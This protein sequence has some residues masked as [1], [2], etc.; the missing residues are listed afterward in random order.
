MKIAGSTLAASCVALASF[1]FNGMNCLVLCAYRTSLFFWM[2]VVCIT[3]EIHLTTSAH[4]Q[5]SGGDRYFPTV[6]RAVLVD[7]FLYLVEFI[8]M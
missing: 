3:R 7:N 6:C 8:W 2:L 1:N 5:Q 4:W